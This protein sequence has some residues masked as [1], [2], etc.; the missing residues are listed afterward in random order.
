MIGIGNGLVIPLIVQGVLQSVP[1][2]RTGAASGVL[3]TTQQFS[4]V[5][6]IAAV[7]TLFFARE[8]S[9]GI[10]SALQ[11][12][13]YADIALVSFALVMTL[14]LP[15]TA[16]TRSA[17]APVLAEGAEEPAMFDGGHLDRQQPRPQM[18]RL[19]RCSPL[20]SIESPR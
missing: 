2:Y 6:G 15:R 11:A 17:A 16:T 4:M 20:T 14:L 18:L 5:L 8:A 7:G 10:V 13:L 19:R 3:T 9:A 12:G 1:S